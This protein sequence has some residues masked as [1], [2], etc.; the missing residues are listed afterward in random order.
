MYDT[1]TFLISCK[2]SERFIRK[3][4]PLLI[5]IFVAAAIARTDITCDQWVVT[6]PVENI[7]AS[8]LT[9]SSFG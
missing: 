4:F 8:D 3:H 2:G 9:P 5:L 1:V 6:F 7:P